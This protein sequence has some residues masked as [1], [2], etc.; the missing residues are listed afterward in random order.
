MPD[1]AGGAG[2][3]GGA[4]A[5]PGQDLYSVPDKSRAAQDP[6]EDMYSVP[7]KNGEAVSATPPKMPKKSPAKGAG[8]AAGA[9][10]DIGGH[11]AEADAK[12]LPKLAAMANAKPAG[13]ARSKSSNPSPYAVA[14]V[15]DASPDASDGEDGED[16]EDVLAGE[17]E[18]FPR[19]R[20]KAE[21]GGAAKWYAPNTHMHRRIH[22]P[23]LRCPCARTSV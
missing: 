19:L 10:E 6:A 14:E 4:G 17:A 8:G 11:L 20:A 2:G 12:V 9:A 1:K 23:A 13:I 15:A 18:A 22:T 3:A 21:A 7:N 5:D 16:G